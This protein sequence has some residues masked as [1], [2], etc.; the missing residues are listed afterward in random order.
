MHVRIW[1]DGTS[2]SKVLKDFDSF[3]RSFN[4]DMR[5]F[6]K[7][8]NSQMG[9]FTRSI[10]D[11]LYGFSDE[12]RTMQDNV[13]KNL[14]SS[15]YKGLTGFDRGIRRVQTMQAQFKKSQ[16]EVQALAEASGTSIEKVF[17]K[18]YLNQ[19]LDSKDALVRESAR[20]DVDSGSSMVVFKEILS[21][22]KAGGDASIIKDLAN[23]LKSDKN[24]YHEL[25]QEQRDLV[26][27]IGNA[28]V[29]EGTFSKESKEKPFG[30]AEDK[31]EATIE[32]LEQSL[33]GIANT[34][35]LFTKLVKDAEGKLSIQS[36]VEMSSKDKMIVQ[37]A[38]N[39]SKQEQVAQRAEV[40]VKERAEGTYREEAGEGL[41]EAFSSLSSRD[42]LGAFKGLG[43]VISGGA[44]GVGSHIAPGK[45]PVSAFLGDGIG[46]LVK[47]LG[48]VMKFIG[49]FL[50]GFTAI[51]KVI[52]DANAQQKEWNQEILKG[53]GFID[54]GVDKTQDFKDG[55]KTI[56]TAASEV[57]FNLEFMTNAKEHLEIVNAFT[58]FGMSLKDLGAGSVTMN[59]NMKGMAINTESLKNK[60]QSLT[61]SVV[62][63][64]TAFGTSFTEMADMQAKAA[65]DFG[66][67]LTAVQDRFYDI[68]QN[69]KL[70]GFGSKR[71]LGMLMQVSTGL[72]MYNTRWQQL[73]TMIVKFS[74]TL[75]P[76]AAKKLMD[77]FAGAFQGKGVTDYL[78][79]AIVG[80]K[81][82]TTDVFKDDAEQHLRKFT[83]DLGQVNGHLDLFKDALKAEGID[84]NIYAGMD[85]QDLAKA[86][87]KL[88]KV[89]VGT[90]GRVESTLAELARDRGI[91][92]VE[93]ITRLL[94]TLFDLA[95]GTTGN[96]GDQTAGMARL[97]SGAVMDLL[98][99]QGSHI[100]KGRKIHEIK[101]DPVAR[102][103]FQAF[104]QM[105]EE[106]YH[107]MADLSSRASADFEKAQSYLQ[108]YKQNASKDMKDTDPAQEKIL[109]ALFNLGLTVN[110]TG[111]A[112]NH[113]VAATG[114]T[115]Q[116]RVK[117][118]RKMLNY[119]DYLKSSDE[120]NDRDSAIAE[121]AKSLAQQ[122][123]DETQ[124]IEKAMQ[125]VLDRLF[126]MIANLVK[127]SD[128][129]RS[130]FGWISSKGDSTKE[131]TA[132]AREEE[133]TAIGLRMDEAITAKTNTRTAYDE[134]VAKRKA[135]EADKNLS[136]KERKEKIDAA[137]AAE[138]KAFDEKVKAEENLATVKADALALKNSK[139]T[140]SEDEKK[141]WQGG[142][143]NKTKAYNELNSLGYSN[144]TTGKTQKELEDL[145]LKAKFGE[146]LKKAG[147][148][149]K[150]AQGV[151]VTKTWVEDTSKSTQSMLLTAL[152]RGDLGTILSAG[153]MLNGMANMDSA[154]FL[155]WSGNGSYYK[156]NANRGDDLDLSKKDDRELQQLYT[157]YDQQGGARDATDPNKRDAESFFQ[158]I[159][160]KQAEM[161]ATL[162]TWDAQ[163]ALSG[164][165]G[166]QAAVDTYKT[167]YGNGYKRDFDTAI[168]QKMLTESSDSQAQKDQEALY[169][170]VLKDLKLTKTDANG[171]PI[172]LKPEDA[173]HI[174]RRMQQEAASSPQKKRDQ[175]QEE[176]TQVLKSILDTL[177]ETN[178]VGSLKSSKFYTDLNDDDKAAAEQQYR[179][180]FRSGGQLK[181]TKEG[182][183]E[184]TLTALPSLVVKPETPNVTAEPVKDFVIL[185]GVLYPVPD[186]A[187]AR[188][189]GKFWQGDPNDRPMPFGRP[190][191]AFSQ[192]AGS[193]AGMMFNINIDNNF[194]V[195]GGPQQAT[196]FAS[197]LTSAIDSRLRALGVKLKKN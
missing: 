60:I 125:A 12:L 153:G 53:S 32:H 5:T 185:N 57:M 94:P 104:S 70:A 56:R 142:L 179:N 68:Y 110:D 119:L 102:A 89:S 67:S 46:S 173:A 26:S 7:N 88:S 50:G 135:V 41:K 91:G 76:D 169:D 194:Q 96:L 146:N 154:Q 120:Y 144:V 164:K 95:K 197:F 175:T 127:L 78:R 123:L 30:M 150:D 170:K 141:G 137:K 93:N 42:L 58:K 195:T 171:K 35:G 136:G 126:E 86:I 75:A 111:N 17:K 81:Q 20:K 196:Q 145:L 47:Q 184:R 108:Q 40:Q 188:K 74:K 49:P 182:I 85:Q 51:F 134:A 6:N 43:G 192:V 103:A 61:S 2:R 139:L 155:R 77:G 9:D 10:K 73:G 8:V 159:Q 92:D 107:Q 168:L 38:E 112:A 166:S 79:V 64:S 21:Q 16:R 31:L 140:L 69:A 63:M 122:Q 52:M 33:E 37:G 172:T 27:R 114:S 44:K 124:S 39:A 55:L 19:R 109:K 84:A 186:G 100:L 13:F 118:D 106:Q 190:G 15:M 105:S 65:E 129:S 59:D 4:K 128:I 138:K 147:K 158:F 11:S 71:F 1:M 193:G 24:L 28:E 18:K 174:V 177:L 72:N 181:P 163:G 36:D 121:E 25:T 130:I 80:G 99:K 62:I 34:T 151:D 98:T 183:L 176:H 101:N 54:L 152:G 178:N 116:S 23:Q 115:F 165:S 45:D 132:R 83:N 133:T 113:L 149:I 48:G 191:G 148:P 180:Y 90:S 131:A 117:T 3:S 160:K 161:F 189:M 22:I 29:S 97:G 82:N 167:A 187:T 87:N 14:E 156:S 143:L 162:S 157:L 66:M